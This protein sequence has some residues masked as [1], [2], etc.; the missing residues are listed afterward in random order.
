MLVHFLFNTTRGRREESGNSDASEDGG[1]ISTQGYTMI[2]AN[3]ESRC[4][5]FFIHLC[6][7]VTL[8]KR[9]I[10]WDTGVLGP[11]SLDVGHSPQENPLADSLLRCEQSGS[12]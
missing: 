10:Q 8:G 7:S 9:L 6:A 3:G 4:P 11:G 2:P 12:N 5:N 1:S